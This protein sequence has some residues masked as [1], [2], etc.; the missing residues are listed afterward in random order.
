[1]G[2]DGGANHYFIASQHRI[3]LSDLLNNHANGI[4]L[5]CSDCAGST[6]TM[7]AML[8]VDNVQLVH[9]GSMTLKAIWGIGCPAYTTNLWGGGGHGFSYH[10]IIT[11]DAAVHVSDAC[12]CLD[13]DGSPQTTPGIPGYNCDREW[14]GVPSGYEYL[15]AYNQVTRT[16]Q[17]LP[18]IR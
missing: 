13:E 1:M 3:E 5:N 15:S 16:V 12:M 18:T 9:L 8:G 10:K 17:A 2:G 14:E 4:Y 6:S 7:L 11:R